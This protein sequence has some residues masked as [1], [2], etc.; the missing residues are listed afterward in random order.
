M[1]HLKSSAHEE[2]KKKG[3]WS[4][5]SVK[6]QTQLRGRGAGP[7]D[8]VQLGRDALPGGAST[9]QVAKESLGRRKLRKKA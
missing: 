6:G 4:N 8:C 2:E 3:V 7:D 5:T 9:R 1:Q